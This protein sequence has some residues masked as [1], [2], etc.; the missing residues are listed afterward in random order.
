MAKKT[1]FQGIDPGTVSYFNIDDERSYG[2]WM[3]SMCKEIGTV[4][5][6][7]SELYMIRLKIH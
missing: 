3:N 1:V 5:G 2:V 6:T 7:E 4:L